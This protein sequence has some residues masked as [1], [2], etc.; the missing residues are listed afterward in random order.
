MQREFLIASEGLE[1]V[2]YVSKNR[3]LKQNTQ[4]NACTYIIKLLANQA[5][6]SFCR[7]PFHVVAIRVEVAAVNVLHKC[8]D[9]SRK[10]IMCCD[11]P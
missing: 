8:R 7:R 1:R 2:E 9:A 3:N 5:V 10:V 11:N 4:H 6:V